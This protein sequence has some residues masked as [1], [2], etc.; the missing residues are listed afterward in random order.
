MTE[1]LKEAWSIT[2]YA[3]KSSLRH[4]AGLIIVITPFLMYFIGSYV[5]KERGYFAV[6]GEALVPFILLFV[7]WTF[8]IAASRNGKHGFP[9]PMR[10]F[11]E[12]TFPGEITVKQQ[13][14]QEM[15]LY[16][17]EVENYLERLGRL[18]GKVRDKAEEE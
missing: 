3:L 11:T 12:E 17:Y 7:A 14:V 10:R 9:V 16:V 1:V 8:D 13:D 18:N 6:G 2:R 5:Y 15:I 4:M